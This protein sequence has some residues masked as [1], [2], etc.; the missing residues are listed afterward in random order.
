MNGAAVFDTV[1]GL[2]LIIAQ[3]RLTSDAVVSAVV[4][5]VD[6]AFR[7]RAEG[8]PCGEG[9][10]RAAQRKGRRTLFVDAREKLIHDSIV[11]GVRRANEGVV[12]VTR[13]VECRVL[14]R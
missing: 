4:L 11:L 8:Q 6:V 14:T 10:A 12:P 2:H 5:F 7:K 13:E 9:R 1:D 3:I